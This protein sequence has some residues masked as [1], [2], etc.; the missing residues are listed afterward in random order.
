MYCP[1]CWELIDPAVHYCDECGGFYRELTYK[2]QFG[3]LPNSYLHKKSK[4]KK[5]KPP[6]TWGKCAVCGGVAQS[7]HH[8]FY[9]RHFPKL[10]HHRNNVIK[11]CMK[12]HEE[13]HSRRA[14]FCNDSSR[15]DLK[16]LLD[17]HNIQSLSS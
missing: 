8:I 15:F 5:R 3:Y 9:R 14:F 11:L 13:I 16:F 2:E 17:C 12:C 1:Y 10:E 4:S 7:H 6:V